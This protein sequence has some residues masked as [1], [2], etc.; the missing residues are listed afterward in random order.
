MKENKWR[1]LTTRLRVNG[2]EARM[3]AYCA[4]YLSERVFLH[5]STFG[6]LL[7]RLDV[8]RVW[9]HVYFLMTGTL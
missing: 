4:N 9:R 7:L 3:P 5:I 8:N 6:T 1:L 2:G